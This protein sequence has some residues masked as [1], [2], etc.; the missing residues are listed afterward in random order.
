MP[1][2]KGSKN[3]ASKVG[4]TKHK[5]PKATA[6]PAKA[7]KPKN[8]SS[9]HRRTKDVLKPTIREYGL[10]NKS[11]SSSK[12]AS[13]TRKPRAKK[14]LRVPQKTVNVYHYDHV[15]AWDWLMIAT[16]VIVLILVGFIAAKVLS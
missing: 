14:D 13:T 5:A 3:A 8:G 11:V 12:V 2:T 15:E 6:R 9:V 10:E 1:R 7:N 16:G 4:A